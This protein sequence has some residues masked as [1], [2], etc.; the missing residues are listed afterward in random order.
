MPSDEIRKL[1]TTDKLLLGTQKTMK[2]LRAGNVKK[3]FLAKNAPDQTKKDLEYYSTLS[4]FQTELLSETN[5]EL[6]VLCKRP[7]SI[8][9]IG[10]KK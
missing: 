2:E 1:L 7:H 3:V 5:E 8:S 10:L 4:E 6:G 9:V